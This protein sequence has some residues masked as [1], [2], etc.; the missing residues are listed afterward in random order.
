MANFARRSRP[1]RDDGGVAALDE[2]PLVG[3]DEGRVGVADGGE[4]QDAV[5]GDGDVRE[6]REDAAGDDLSGR[7]VVRVLV[8][9][10]DPVVARG[11]ERRR[12]V[13]RPRAAGQPDELVDGRALGPEELAGA[14]ADADARPPR[15]VE[16]PP[17]VRRQR[18]APVLLVD[19]VRR[20]DRAAPVDVVAAVLRPL[21]LALERRRGVDRVL[22]PLQEVLLGLLERL[23]PARVAAPLLEGRDQ[24]V[25]PQ[26]PRAE[27]PQRPL[28]VLGLL[29]GPRDLHLQPRLPAHALGRPLV[30]L[31]V[32]D[33]PPKELRRRPLLPVQ[34]PRRPQ[35]VALPEGRHRAAAAR[36]D[37]E[38]AG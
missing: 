25:A 34:H 35:G 8:L 30:A 33:A 5:A 9:E 27:V 4:V 28:L 15:R 29:D 23:E 26:L 24:P 7:V 21:A 10:Y 22:A 17:R 18:A 3:G 11:P 2:A 14:V 1:V 19:V 16:E 36:H 6:A 12:R 37:G 13:R 31:V 38:G 20:R 32:V